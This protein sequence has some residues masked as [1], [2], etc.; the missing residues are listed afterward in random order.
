LN[1]YGQN[2]INGLLFLVAEYM[3]CCNMIEDLLLNFFANF[4]A[5]SI[6]HINKPNN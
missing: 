3:L 5:S 4:R 2:E 1:N 6:C